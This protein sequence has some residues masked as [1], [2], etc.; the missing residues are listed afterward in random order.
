MLYDAIR[1]ALP[2]LQAEAESLMALTLT[3]YSPGEPSTDADGYEVIPYANEGDTPGK[4]QSGTQ[5]GSDT[6]TRHVSIGGVE[7]PVL[8]GG[9]HIPIAAFIADGSLSIV[10][11]EQSGIGWEFEVAA[12]GPADDPAL[13]G[14]RYLVVG[15]PA[16]SHATAR[17]LD[18]VEV[19]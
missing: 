13:L 8:S 19:Q 7:R 18:V 4:V 12:T 11:S 6:P 10:A 14:R 5:S 9:L 15:V 17:R 16:K 2:E 3:A 1:G